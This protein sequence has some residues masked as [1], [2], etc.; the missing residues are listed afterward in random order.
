M[1]FCD[2]FLFYHIWEDR[3][4]KLFRIR[5]SNLLPAEGLLC[6]QFFYERLQLL[7]CH[8]SVFLQRLF[9]F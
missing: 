6:C 1:C 8:G 4:E 2:H 9:Y 7:F 3:V 5:Y